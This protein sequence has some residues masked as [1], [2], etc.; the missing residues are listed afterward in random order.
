MKFDYKWGMLVAGVWFILVAA[1]DLGI[2]S[3]DALHSAILPLLALAAG[4]IFIV[5]IFY[6]KRK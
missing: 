1:R 5:G 6:E 4:I 3:I 2:F